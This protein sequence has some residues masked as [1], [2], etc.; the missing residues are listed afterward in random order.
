MKYHASFLA[1]RSAWLR[2]SCMNTG[3]RCLDLFLLFA[4][5]TILF[6]FSKLLKRTNICLALPCVSCPTLYAKSISARRSCLFLQPGKSSCSYINWATVFFTSSFLWYSW[7]FEILIFLERFCL[8]TLFILSSHSSSLL[9]HLA[10]SCSAFVTR[11]ASLLKDCIFMSSFLAWSSFHFLLASNSIFINS[12]ALSTS[13]ILSSILSSP[14]DFVSIFLHIVSIF[15][16]AAS[17]SSDTSLLMYLASLV[18]ILLLSTSILFWTSVCT[19]L[20]ILSWKICWFS[21]NFAFIVL[22]WKFSTWKSLLSNS[23]VGCICVSTEVAPVCVSSIFPQLSGFSTSMAILY[24]S[25]SVCEFNSFCTFFNSSSSLFNCG[26]SLG[27]GNCGPFFAFFPLGL[28][29]FLLLEFCW[30]FGI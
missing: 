9:L 23:D 26:L 17:L 2:S 19:E 1:C 11:S 20:I 24:S 27:G 18:F 13:L 8:S 12:I 6:L 30:C 29:F 10:N 22:N 4:C 15:A 3:L 21:S 5:L 7:R 25:S 28:S 14:W 16:S